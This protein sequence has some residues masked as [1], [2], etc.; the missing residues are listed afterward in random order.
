MKVVGIDVGGTAVKFGYFIDGVLKEKL[1]L[2]T[3]RDLIKVMKTGISSLASLDELD[4]I[5]V[6]VPAPIKD[7]FMFNAANMPWGN[8]N[9]KELLQTELAFKS[10]EVLN[11]A[12]AACIGEYYF[13]E[14]HDSAVLI[15]LGTGVGGG[16][17]V[18]GKL[19]EGHNGF[20]GE[21]GHIHLDDEFGFKCGCGSVGCCETVA[22][23]TGL[24]NIYNAISNKEVDARTI[25]DMAKENDADALTSV[26]LYSKY[27][28][29]LCQTLAFIINPQVFIIGG[30]VSKAGMF[31]LD[32][33]T[34]EYTKLNTYK[35]LNKLEF[36]L[37][38]LGNDAGIYG[39]YYN[40]LKKQPEE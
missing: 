17:I 36:K 9:I 19:V 4:S 24:S 21:I 25:F 16:I 27:I 26:D 15:T 13:A 28:A 39:A 40:S 1:E 33:I 18:D 22:S 23:A 6:A 38:N 8:L 32:K 35:E 3:E 30:G 34:E 14:M 11:D 37:A 10:I 7:N 31:L 29:R 20:G 5:G 12:N 2:K